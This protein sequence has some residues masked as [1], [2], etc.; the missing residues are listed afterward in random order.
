MRRLYFVLTMLVLGVTACIP[1]NNILTETTPTSTQSLNLLV[2]IS[3]ITPIP[4][5]ANPSVTSIVTDCSY[6]D[7]PEAQLVYPELQAIESEQVVPG[8]VIKI[9]ARGGYTT[10]EDECGTGYNESHRTFAW[11]LDDEYQGEI[12]CYVNHCETEFELPPDISVGT[13]TIEV[14]GGSQIS[15]E[16]ST[17]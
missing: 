15:L 9:T 4:P 12:G 14:E 7:S 3:S 6:G 13:H 8:Q 1:Y 5:T 2:T 16:V 11:F 10:W 17:R